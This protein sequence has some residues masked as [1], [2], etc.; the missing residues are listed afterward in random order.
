MCRVSDYFRLS[1]LISARVFTAAS[2]S[3]QTE[4]FPRVR[5]FFALSALDPHEL[6]R[7]CQAEEPR[8]DSLKLQ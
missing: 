5:V 3:S 4:T 6:V 7:K 8:S 1:R 2:H